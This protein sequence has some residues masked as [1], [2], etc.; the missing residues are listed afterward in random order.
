MS[1]FVAQFRFRS[2]VRFG[3]DPPRSESSEEK[4]HSDTL[5]SG[6]CHSWALLHGKSGLDALLSQFDE[7]PPFLLSSGFVFTKDTFFL[8]KPLSQFPGFEASETG[9]KILDAE[10]VL[11]AAGFLG[12]KDFECWAAA[13]RVSLSSFLESQAQYQASF[14]PLETPRA[15]VSR[16]DLGFSAFRCSAVQFSDDCGLY[17]L[18][19]FAD[20]RLAEKTRQSLRFLGEIGVGGERSFGYGRF[21]LTFEPADEKWNRLFN[22]RGELFLCLSLCHPASIG[23]DLLQG[24]SYQLLRRRGRCYSPFASEQPKRK[25]VVMFGEGSVF[26]RQIEGHLVDVTPSS[27]DRRELHPIY[28]YGYALTVP[29]RRAEPRPIRA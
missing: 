7:S 16:S 13:E 10:R 1:V 2:P 24:A 22:Q 25:S 18:F 14:S 4:V 5:F 23:P 15:A 20:D 8:P 29:I 19:R 21:E 11:R 28:R 17:V 27:W 12:F 9:S 26:R 6:L 3:I